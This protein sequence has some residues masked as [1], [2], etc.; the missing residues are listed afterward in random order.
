MFCFSEC[1]QVSRQYVNTNLRWTRRA[2]R[3]MPFGRN[4]RQCAT[5]S[6]T[7]P[8]LVVKNRKKWMNILLAVCARRVK[9]LMAFKLAKLSRCKRPEIRH[10]TTKRSQA[11]CDR[12]Y[13]NHTVAGRPVALGCITGI[14]ALPRKFGEQSILREVADVVNVGH[15]KF[16]ATSWR[17]HGLFAGALAALWA[18]P[19][20]AEVLKSDGRQNK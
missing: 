20:R 5:R 9:R 10:Y 15:T 7:E 3:G 6:F 19:A 17:S 13:E 12:Y 1:W 2:L 11:R 18:P 16:N 14:R 4:W 8:T